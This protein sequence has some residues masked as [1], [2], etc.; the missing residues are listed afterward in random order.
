MGYLAHPNVQTPSHDTVIW[1][2]MDLPKFLLMLEQRGL[3]FSLLTEFSDKW[4]AVIGRELTQG[5]STQFM[6]ASGDVIQLF[7]EYSKRTAVNCWYQGKGESIAMWGLYTKSEFCVAIK[8]TVRDLMRALSVYERDVFIGKVE[9]QDHT[10]PPLRTLAQ[11]DITPYKAI[12]QKRTCYQHECEL[13]VITHLTPKFPEDAQ[14]G[15]VIVEPFPVRG[16]VVPVDLG[17]LI[18]SVI[19]GP[20]FPGWAWELLTSGLKRAGIDPPVL[21]SDAFKPPTALFIEG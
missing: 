21:E 20:H 10:A 5:I 18:H 4:E 2:Y 15:V 1:R 14:P 13:R 8:S 16:K 19:T 3:Y 11:E 6:S 12:L 9:Y 7:R 17:T